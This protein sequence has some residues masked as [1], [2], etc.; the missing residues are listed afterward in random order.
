[1]NTQI[2]KGIEMLAE[3]LISI[4]E[5]LKADSAVSSAPVEQDVPKTQIEVSKPVETPK[6]E[7]VAV[8]AEVKKSSE[9]SEDEL[10]G[11]SYNE[12]KKLA[13]ELGISAVG[14]RKEL[15]KKIL[16]NNST[17]E[18]VEVEDD[19]VVE[20]PKTVKKTSKDETEKEKKSFKKTVSKPKVEEPEPVEDE[21]EDV[22]EEDTEDEAL[23]DTTE[24]RVIEATEEMSDDELRELLEDVGVPSKGKRQALITKLVTAVEDGLIELDGE[25]EETDEEATEETETEESADVTEGM[26][27]KR[28][29][30]YEELC[31]ET[32]KALED[33][34]IQRD[35]LIEFINAFNGTDDKFKKLSTEDLLD[36][37]LE[38][39]AMLV[40]DDGNVVEEGAYTINDEPY[41]CGHPLDYDEDREVFKCCCCGS[42]YE[43]E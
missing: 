38:L 7:D 24:S 8:V 4:A 36:K 21:D 27:K 9:Y 20:Q 3:G 40:D 14:N 28:K 22:G 37:Y 35:D 19:E 31:D 29:E 13:K 6:E 32:T 39:S 16:T 33:G 11:M 43:A 1:M 42:E 12:I 26:T 25:D 30:A 10:S 17:T 23:E 34:E 5:G 15:V 41:C 18:S 2:I